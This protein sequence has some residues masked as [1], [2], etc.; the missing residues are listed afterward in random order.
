MEVCLFQ[1]PSLGQDTEILLGIWARDL[2]TMHV[3]SVLLLA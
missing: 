3:S 1:E 2:G